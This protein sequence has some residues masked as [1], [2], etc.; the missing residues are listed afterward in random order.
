MDSCADNVQRH[1]VRV[2]NALLTIRCNAPWPGVG[3]TGAT[4]RRFLGSN[5]ARNFFLCAV[6]RPVRKSFG[7]WGRG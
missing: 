6:V 2:N 7:L 5:S 4:L 3:A 1:I